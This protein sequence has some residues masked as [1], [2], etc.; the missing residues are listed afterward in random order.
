MKKWGFLVALVVILAGLAITNPDK[1]DF[2]EWYLDDVKGKTVAGTS[3]EALA[4][5]LL[6]DAAIVLLNNNTEVTNYLIFS[7]YD[8]EIYGFKYQY[9]G[10]ATMFIDISPEETE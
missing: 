1:D 5:D 2:R 8:L 10:I 7:F 4:D 3:F 9:L 6:S